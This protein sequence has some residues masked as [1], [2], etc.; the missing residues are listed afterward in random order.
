MKANLKKLLTEYNVILVL[1]AIGVC[2]V[3]WVPFFAKAT[4]LAKL[5]ADLSMYGIVAIG[6]TFLLISGEIDLSLGMS[7][8]LATIIS[9]LVGSN[10]GG[11][12]GILAAIAVCTLIGCINGLFVSRLRINSLIV[13][14]AMMTAL[15]G[16]CYLVGNGQTV[17]NT[18]DF[19]RSLYTWRL[20]GFRFLQL[21][22]VVFI[23][24][25]IGFGILLHRTKFGTSVFVAGGNAEAG[26]MS[27]ID[28]GRVKFMCFIIA[29][30][31]AGITG[32]FLASY[33]YAGA[34]TYGEG[35]NITLISA[36]VVGGVKFTGGKGGV[37]RTL[38]GIAVVRAVIN[39]T[40]LLNFDAWAQN[41]VTGAL[42]LIV[43]IVDRCTREQKLEESA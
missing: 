30:I 23:L 40:S 34:A 33:V 14:I 26:Y 43:L 28:V 12:W 2:G 18:S 9:S 7:I 24:C 8:A 39:I 1:L 35:L 36:C 5:L 25:L 42:L 3:L 19:L 41:I 17:A 10:L 38:L 21:P 16:V 37:I 27:G 4:N 13:S 32:V 31:C 22:T 20:F 11:V 6:M 15:T 29:G